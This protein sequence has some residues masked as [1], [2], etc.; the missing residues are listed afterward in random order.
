MKKFGGNMK[1]FGQTLSRNVTL[2]IVA[3]GA[4]SVAA[5]DQQAKALAQVEAGLISTGNAA[6]FTSQQL[7]KMAADLQAKTLFG[8]EDILQ[9]ATA[10]LLTFTN[11]AGKE[12]AR[13]QKVVTDLATKS[14]KGD[15]KSAS[16]QLG[17]ALNDPIANLSALSRAGIQFSVEQKAIIKSLVETNKLAEAQT[18]ILDELET[19][20]GGAAEAAAKAGLGPFQQ[21]QN[22]LMDVSEE[23]GKLIVENIEPF[24]KIILDVIKVLR[25]LNDEQKE[26]IIKYGGLAAVIGPVIVVIGSLVSTLSTV[27]PLII[28]FVAAITPVGA[29]IGAAVLAVGYLTK[30]MIDLNDEWK[31]YQETTDDLDL[32][33]VVGDFEKLSTLSA[34][35]AKNTKKIS[36]EKAAIPQRIASKKPGAIATDTGIPE[37]LEGVADIEPSGLSTFSEAFFDFSE[38]FKSSIQNTFSEISGLMGGVS[39]L[40]SQLHNKR[41]I[42][43]DNERAAELAKIESTIVGEDAKEN[44]INKLNEKYDKK[45]AQLDKKQAIRSKKI[46]ILEAIVNTA[47]AVVE[48]LPK[49]PLAI[50]VGALGA[51]QIATIASTPIPAFADG[52]IVSGPTVGL[53]G[54]YAG[55]NTNPEVIAP[56]NKLKDMIGGNTVQVQGMISGEDIYLSNDRYSR[57]VNSY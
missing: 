18:I 54:E 14:F 39:N 27:I 17:K 28:G 36:F 3:L 31:E 29:I 43:L 38:D 15:L 25:S 51:A 24:K 37:T 40:F 6:G 53:M 8:D 48:S 12:F 30:R 2:P 44:A 34:T 21:L 50:A 47:S 49:L 23:F 7:Q 41:M 56:L 35:L 13:T 1:S 52:G 9:N 19:Q 55:A 11:I 20:F 26:A 4:A 22:S 32:G 45:K 57:R 33:P 42:E 46:A 10:Q 16:I 5:F